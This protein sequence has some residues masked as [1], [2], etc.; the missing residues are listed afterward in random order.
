MSKANTRDTVLCHRE[1]H[2]HEEGFHP[3][4]KSHGVDK[5]MI[6]Q[7]NHQGSGYVHVVTASISLSLSFPFSISLYKQHNT[8]TPN[9]APK[10]DTAVGKHMA[11]DE[12]TALDDERGSN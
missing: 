2:K 3:T 4:A 8:P 5:S 9:R 1:T 11:A 6:A 12:T 7:G 10:G